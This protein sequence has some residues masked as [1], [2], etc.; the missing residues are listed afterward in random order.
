MIYLLGPHGEHCYTN[1]FQSL[2]I[3]DSFCVHLL[4]SKA[5]GYGIVVFSVFLKLPQ[6]IKIL[7]HKNALGIHVN[8]FFFESA[9][10]LPIVFFNLRHVLYIY[11]YILLITAVEI[12]ILHLWRVLCDPS[13]KHCSIASRLFVFLPF[14]PQ[15]ILVILKKSMRPNP[16]SIAI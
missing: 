15:T 13:S 14:P 6:I 8:T 4:I 9:A 12:S 5:L 2:L 7:Y 1:L 16:P 11:I 3:N 10:N